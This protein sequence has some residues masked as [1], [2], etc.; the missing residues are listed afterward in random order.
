MTNRL[1]A[2]IVG[3]ER[4]GLRRGVRGDRVFVKSRIK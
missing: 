1:T 2:G 3:N 4:T